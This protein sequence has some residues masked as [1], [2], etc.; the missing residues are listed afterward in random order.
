M[1]P[2][3]TEPGT[4]STETPTE[5][6]DQ[7][8]QPTQANVAEQI[9]SLAELTPEQRALLMLRLR[10]KAAERKEAEGEV[11]ESRGIE[12]VR[13]E[14]GVRLSFAQQRLWVLHQLDPQSSA[15]NIPSAYE[16]VGHL[17]VVALRSLI[18]EIV[19]RHEPL[20][21]R[22]IEGDDGPLQ[23][24]DEA[25]PVELPEVDLS[26]IEGEAAHEEA[27]RVCKQQAS[28]PFSLSE[29][30]LM[31]LCLIR[32]GADR[33][34][35]MVNQHHIISDGWSSGVMMREV[36]ALY[37]AYV[38]GEGSPLREL[39]V[40]YADYAEWQR[41]RLERGEM[42]QQREYW[43]RQLEAAAPVLEL[44]YDRPRPAVPTLRGGRQEISIS[45]EAVERIRA[46]SHSQGA[47]L[48]MGLLACFKGVMYR[49]S[50]QQDIVVGTPVAGRS[51][52][53]LEPLIGFFVNTVAVRTKVEGEMSYRELVGRVRESAIGAYMNEELPFE[54]VVRQQGGSRGAGQSPI[55]E[56][57]MI[58]QNAPREEGGLEGLSIKGIEMDNG[59][60]KY[61]LVMNLT[62]WEGGVRGWV[63]YQEEV[64]D[65]ETVERMSRHYERVVEA[66]GERDGQSKVSELEMMSEAEQR[67]VVEEWNRTEREYE[68]G[69]SI[70]GMIERQ[71][72]ERGAEVA[73][74]SGGERVSYSQ[75]NEKANKVANYLR[76]RGVGQE[77][78]VGVYMQRGVGMVEGLVGVMKAGG[79]YLPLDP[80]YPKA[81]LEYILKDAR[82]TVVLTQRELVSQLPEHEAEVICLDSD[83]AKISEEDDANLAT[84]TSDKNLI[85][86]IY[87]SGSTGNPKGAMLTH[88]GITNSIQW[89]QETYDLEPEDRFLVRTSLNFDPSVWEIFWPLCV[90]ASLVIADEAHHQ[91]TAYLVKLIGQQEVT[92]AYFIP[93]LLKAMIEEP[94][95]KECRSLR[96]IICGGE[97]LSIETVNQL[98][99]CLPVELHH[100]YG[101]TET[102]IAAT[103]WTCEPSSRREV[104]PIGRPLGNTRV[105]VLDE[106]MKAVPVGIAGELYIGGVSVGRGYLN[107]AELTAERYVPDSYSK[108][109]GGRL[110]RTGD[111]VRYEVDGTIQYLGRVD[112]QLKIN[113]VRIEAGEIEAIVSEHEGVE[114]CAVIAREE[115]GAGKQ[116]VGY[117]VKKEGA[118]AGVVELR[119]HLR[120]RVPGYM[121]PSVW[122]WMK[123]L[124]MTPSGKVD[125]RSLPEPTKGRK[126]EAESERRR[127]AV[128][129]VEEV[130]AGIWEEVLRVEGVEIDENFFE[131]GGHSLIATQLA[132]KLQRAFNTEIELRMIFERPT[133]EEQ[134]AEINRRLRLGGETLESSVIE[135][136]RREGGVRL[137]FAQQRLWVLH[138]LDP[139]SSA[140]NIPSAY[141]MVGQ[142]D[143]VALRSLIREIV[144]RH[145]PLR[146]RFIEGDDGPLQVIDEAG[147]VELPEVDLSQIEGE[148]AREE[149]MRVCRQQ[150]SEPFSLSEGELMRLCLIR[151]GADR[152]VLMVNQHHIIS[153]GWSS[154]VMMREVMALYGAYVKGEG[155][156]LRELEVQYADY[157]EWQRGRLERGEMDGQREYW[158][159]QLEAAAPVLELPYDRPRPLVPTLRGGRQEISISREA[160]E[161]IRAISHSQGATLFMGLLACFKGVMYRYSGQQ[162][163]VVGTPVAGRSRQELE[164]LIGFFVNTVAVRTRV[165][166][167]MS[168]RELV[169]R[170]RESAIGAY[171]N[172]ELPFEEV[173]RQQVRGRE[174]GQSPIFEVMMILQNAPR[175][176]GGLE[177]LSLRAIEM[178]NGES[179]YSLVMNLTE[180]EGGVRGWLGYQEEVLDEET[181]ERMS[182]HYE[183]VVEEAGTSDGQ[184]KVSELEM[185]SEAEQRQV[186]EE[187][188]RTEREYERGA[189]IKGMIERQ[190]EERGAEIAVESG[191]ER[192]SYSQLNEKGNKV[193]NYLRKRGVGQEQI[194]GVYMQRGVGMVEGLVGVMKAG[195]AYLP[196]DPAYPKARLEYI[197]KDARPT[198]VLTQRELVSQLP[199]H[200]AEVICLDSDWAKISEED[201]ANLAT[202]TSDKNLIYVIYTSGSTGNPKGAMLTHDGITNSIQWM[203]ETYDLEP[204]DR[205]LVRTSLNFDP[206]VW[207]IF[208]PLCVGA[209]LVIADEAH[210]QDT[211]YLV[212][213]IGQQEVTT[214]YFIPSLLKAMIEE[215]GL[216]ECRSLRRIICG[217][218]SLSIETVNQLMDCL[219]VELH[220]SYGPT[221]TSIAATEWT[222]EPSSRREVVPIGRPLGN[223]RVYVLDEQMKAVPVGIAGELY[224]SGVCV[225]RGYLNR[226]ELTAE[227]YVPDSYSKE[228]GGRLYRTGDLVRYEVDGTIQYLGRVDE[229]LKI[230]GVR[231]EA[232]EIE[233]IVSEHEGVEK[234]AVIAREEEG[235]GKQMV[236][237]VVK[238]EG[239]EAGVVELREHL[240]ER[241]PGYMVPSVWVWMKEL[242]MTPSGK[243][244]RRSLP[245]PDGVR[246]EMEEVFVAPRTLCRAN[247]RGHLGRRGGGEVGG[248]E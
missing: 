4:T 146:T 167:E 173:V 131:M 245:E 19:R 147:P 246:P 1:N 153:D 84:L 91:D 73:V 127:S 50:G 184:S 43:A 197:L 176:E 193:A 59:E 239:A 74:E 234:C 164:P 2:L 203:Q 26:Q 159:R 65:E 118:E 82:P 126:A 33:Q 37:G 208:W 7:S 163:I 85:Y 185:M 133:V 25:G 14:G 219:P 23:V 129:P 149:A 148:A 15:Y 179:K 171:M 111:L 152:Q 72:E 10:N 64:F 83:W 199:E 70:K 194:V 231:I 136:V 77:Q 90:G 201:D 195:G 11:K 125:R 24:I 139:Q 46:I 120:E 38:K 162:D 60:S 192:V 181:V 49:Y 178:D 128:S 161:R 71:A 183:R 137:S 5:P 214:A 109:E 180:S 130:I 39:E 114:K 237:Y 78:I 67:Q 222:C 188:N 156:P 100:S 157:A 134:A 218:E 211:A 103:E 187:W 113:G 54:E 88:D 248:K 20:R 165:E 170:V 32:E 51:R 142:L 13:R 225:G 223:T 18:R 56:V 96:R 121:V 204:E 209:S 119:E 207:E 27:M 16:M 97:S 30:E 41:G 36:V 224:I 166:G 79:A 28:Q 205:F 42:E 68:A 141:E 202:L 63:G 92:T 196:L 21:T 12:R 108:E 80:A 105:Y 233:A 227:R 228:E 94:G 226:A 122:V 99:D 76:K 168:Y 241:V 145:E 240:R 186:V 115:E 235:A 95:L 98:M 31:R 182:R 177:G 217:G 86:V 58:L 154:G 206:S 40:Q 229:Q 93:S 48:F 144:R 69:A 198:V 29:G 61:S 87:T 230:N 47:T 22:F 212:K 45:R 210:H 238:K 112:E 200:E 57:M 52:Q 8:T 169:G 132:R 138:Q 221:E 213:L 242:P 55:F 34:V 150:A 155:S 116:M 244:D 89:M 236:G 81:R 101:P 151:E 158:A 66:A 107:R 189:S 140:Y 247:H 17:D 117:V 174:I 191:G 243:V 9:E 53:E 62:E 232:G 124:P 110:Y 160:V 220:H 135:R 215:P 102:S 172:E 6:E 216:K 75:L 104:V 35:L 106:Q 44:P 3:T 175:E 143:V 123:E 190:A